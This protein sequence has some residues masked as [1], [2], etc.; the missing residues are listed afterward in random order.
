MRICTLLHILKSLLRTS[1]QSLLRM[2]PVSSTAIRSIRTIAP[3]TQITNE[4]AGACDATVQL[5]RTRAVFSQFLESL[6]HTSA[7][8]DSGTELAVI[9]K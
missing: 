8:G 2:L 1:Q 6:R 5:I 7:S 9:G 3:R 4:I